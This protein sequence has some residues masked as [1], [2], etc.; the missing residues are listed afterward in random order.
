MSDGK[1]FSTTKKGE[2]PE[3][4]NDLASLKENVKKEAVKKVIAL[5]TVGKD[6][7]KLFPDVLKCITTT[8]LELKKLVYLYIMNYARNNEEMA[9]MA[10]NTFQQDCSDP[11]PL[12][13]ALAIRTM[14][15]IRVEKIVEY[16]C[17]PL[18]ACL[19]DSHP[20]VSKTAAICVAKLYDMN[21]EL[22]HAKG[23]LDDL[24]GLLADSNP[25]VVAN[26]VAAL[27]EIDEVSP[28]PIFVLN[29]STLS[30][31]VTA[32]DESTEWGQCYFLSCLARYNPKS[33]QEAK[34]IV[35]KVSPAL[36]H[37]NSAVV[38]GAVKVI[39]KYL[40]L[41]ESKEFVSVLLKKIKP[42]LVT[43]L[44][45]EPE[46]KYV[47]LRNINLILQKKPN[48][49][50][51]KIN[52]FFCEFDDPIY[53]KL[54]KLEVMIM[55]VNEKN[56]DALLQEFKEYALDVDVDFV[57]KVIRAIGRTA[58]KFEK[59]AD[60]CVQLLFNLFQNTQA[61]HLTSETIIV[62]KDIF[63]RY[64][65]QY[66][67]I[68]PELVQHAEVLEDPEAIASMAWIIGEH[69]HCIKNPIDSL[70]FFVDNFVDSSAEV[71]NQ[72]LTAVVKV[73]LKKSKEEEM[74]TMLENVLRVATE[75]VQN[76]DVRDRGFIY[77]R[78]LTKTPEYAKQ[79]VLTTKPLIED[80]N[81]TVNPKLLHELIC[82]ISTLSAVYHKLPSQ[83]VPKMRADTQIA[84]AIAKKARVDPDETT[85]AQPD[86]RQQKLHVPTPAVAPPTGG[87]LDL[88]GLGNLGAP[89]ATPAATPTP[90]GG[91]GGIDL[92]LGGGV[93]PVAPPVFSG[94]PSVPSAVPVASGRALPPVKTT[95]AVV[96][97]STDEGANGLQIEAQF[98]MHDNSVKLR[99]IF[100]NQSQQTLDKFLIKFAPNL[101]KAS[102]SVQ[103]LAV[104][105][106]TPGAQGK[107]SVP[108]VF[109]QPGI[110][111]DEANGADIYVAIKS[112]LGMSAFTCAL[113]IHITFTGVGPVA[114][115]VYKQEW[116]NFANQQ[117]FPVVP[118]TRDVNALK[119]HLQG[120]NVFFMAQRTAE[121]SVLLYLSASMADSTLV[122][123]ELELAPSGVRLCVNTNQN[124]YVNLVR[125]SLQAILQQ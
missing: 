27:C 44:T 113:P 84:P 39:M 117:Y 80:P 11:N 85:G 40:D 45:R 4:R 81:Q 94:T 102:P 121:Q 15:C 123:F 124:H 101:Y 104:Q 116:T 105:P 96:Q 115:D 68:I 32:L 65:V 69:V 34:V 26:A 64:P 70:R 72:T 7:S 9:I 90:A 36:Q 61:R 25:M 67:N 119:Q 52:V 79:V 53:V 57:R 59:A 66:E 47:A 6:V 86:P 112:A 41:L 122:L 30:K 54:E 71:Q 46:I 98:V 2:I 60:K 103:S 108:V 89:A 100:T 16:L 55:L 83:F 110:E 107:I 5:M 114:R 125:D 93:T 18:A 78:L 87:V 88:L 77:Y 62:L 120:S 14:G 74:K 20:Y 91:L 49:L 82:Q 19:K 48:L 109:G 38:L 76:P 43:M 33:A 29:R 37:V 31:L 97:R 63:R 95:M 28:E 51:N 50:A 58:I 1:Y 118:S 10:V 17:D 73:F 35:E 13:R 92:G 22:V 75:Q 3:L 106:I 56:L 42:I 24:K 21:P 99:I 8:N 23:F 12:V 111:K